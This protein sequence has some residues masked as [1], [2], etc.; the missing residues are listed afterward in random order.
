MIVLKNVPSIPIPQTNLAKDRVGL[1][2][3]GGPLPTHSGW[4]GVESFI[5][6]MPPFPFCPRVLPL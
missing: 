5:P 2:G 6:G 1:P 3:G 4:R